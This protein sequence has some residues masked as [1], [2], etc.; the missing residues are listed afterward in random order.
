MNMIATS[1]V[2]HP[3][4]VLLP[5]AFHALQAYVGVWALATE[6][7]RNIQRHRQ[8][9]PSI[10]AFKDAMLAQID[11]L[12]AF[13]NR[14]PLAELDEVETTLLKLLLS[15]AEIAPTVE[16]YNQQEVVYG[17]DPRRF[18]AEEDFSLKP[19]Y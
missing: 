11:E 3:V 2:D 10:I 4:N 1:Q 19:V 14:K 12:L 5:E 6:T 8:S 7:E 16:C 18:V 17:F 9:M 15:L 13:L